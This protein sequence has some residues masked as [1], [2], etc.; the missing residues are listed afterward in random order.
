MT[1]LNSNSSRNRY[2]VM[3]QKHTLAAISA[4]SILTLNF[5]TISR[6]SAADSVSL[7]GKEVSAFSAKDYRGKNHSLSDYGDS[8]VVVLAFL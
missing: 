5:A 1:D 7:V 8:R 3:I 6:T 2:N 4:V